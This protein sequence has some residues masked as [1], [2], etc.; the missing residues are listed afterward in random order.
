[1]K[2]FLFLF[3]CMLAIP[4][5]AAKVDLNK[6]TM[7]EL[8]T[9]PITEQQAKDIYDYRQNIAYFEDIYDLRKISSIDQMTMEKI[10]SL[11]TVS[12]YIETDDSVL[13]RQQI[14]YLLQ[15]MDANEGSQ[16]G[17]SDVWE[18]FLM[19]PQNANGMFFNDYLSLPNVSP[20]DAYAVMKRRAQ[21][22]TLA[23]QRDLKNS[24]GLSYY[25]Y[26]NMKNYV[27]YKEPPIKDRL[28]V[29]YQL[30]YQSI[31]YEDDPQAMYKLPLIPQTYGIVASGTVLPDSVMAETNKKENCYWGYFHMDKYEASVLN[32]LRVRYGSNFKAG[33]LYDSPAGSKDM[34]DTEQTDLIKDGK[35]YAGYENTV[36]LF[37]LTGLKAYLGNYRVS[38]G[39]GLTMDNTDYY[40]SRNTG[41]GFTKRILGITPDLSRTQE[42]SMRGGALELKKTWMEASLFYSRDKKDAV[43]YLNQTVDS[44]GVHH[45]SPVKDADGNYQV[46]GYITPTRSFDNESLEKAESFFNQE[47]QTPGYI[48]W[49]KDY[50]NLAPRHDILTETVTGGHLS[51]SPFTG[52]HVGFS[53]YTSVYDN[54]DFYVPSTIDSLKQ[55]LI[56]D[57]YNYKYWKIASSEIKGLYSTKTSKYNRDYRRVIGFDWMSVI[58]NTSIQGEYSE[59]TVDG[60]DTKLG[61]DPKAFVITSYTQFDNLYL[62][63]LF[64]NYDVGFDNP[65]S[66]GFSEHQK[67]TD[68]VLED[69]GYTLTNP[70]LSDMVYNSAQAQAERGLYFE[71]R[72]RFNSYFTLGRTY[73][74]IW[75]RLTDRRKSIRFQ[76][77]LDYRPFYQ[78]SL[79]AKYKKQIN[80]YDETMDRAVSKTDEYTISTAMFLSARDYMSFEYRYNT[81]WGPP[82]LSITNPG[83]AMANNQASGSTQMTGDFIAMNYD[84]NF[85]DDLSITGSVLYWNGH[86]ISHWDWEDTE[87]DFMGLKGM[88][89]WFTIQDQI[90]T[91]LFMSFK[92]KYKEYQTQEEFIRNYNLPYGTQD[93]YFPR[94]E[95]VENEIRFQLDWKF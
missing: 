50:I 26:S 3:L 56:R 28:F 37:G 34:F 63:S 30:K 38:Y 39:E 61:D 54:A 15:R 93:N 69:Y 75:E 66:R 74:D 45:Y 17:M 11:I 10:R 51:L 44:L 25:G 84:H 36:D 70:L 49:A 90:A 31:P 14:G 13:R 60:K 83:Q 68:T 94:V 91:N 87:I 47:L 33:A 29:D 4:L 27:Y 81:V 72:Y 65:Y 5:F 24:P 42:Y 6:A 92:Y 53:T 19:T 77:D 88:K 41:Y 82:Y 89:Y 7:A 59:L 2:K 55:M 58:K 48:P 95:R 12:H 35:F 85:N 78:L 62:L 32:K 79:R 40:T 18:D 57:S 64:R 1:M 21:G 86:G 67:F 46:F 20:V 16:E 9:L 73:M 43:V 22:D 80:R 52:T 71:T 76:G 23:D 8:K